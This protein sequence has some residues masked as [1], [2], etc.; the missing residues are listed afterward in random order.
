MK[1]KLAQI[2]TNGG[3]QPR[4]EI[5][6][7]KVDEYLEDMNNGAV[8]PAIAVFYDGT[9][10]WLADGYHR[11]KAHLKA[12]YHDIECDIHQGTQR[13]AILYSVGAN[14]THG[15]RRTNEDKRRAVN[16]LL[17]D[18]EWSQWSNREIAKRCRVSEGMVR[19]LR[20]KRS[21]TATYTTKHG[22]QATMNTSN[23]GTVQA[24]YDKAP[25]PVK[26]QYNDGQVTAAQ[27]YEITTILEDL[28]LSHIPT[29]GRLVAGNVDK[30]KIIARLYSTSGSP[31]TNGT[32]EALIQSKGIAY[33][34]DNH[35]FVD[36]ESAS[37]DE[38][39]KALRDIAR[40]HAIIETQAAATSE[41]IAKQSKRGNVATLNIT[42]DDSYLKVTIKNNEITCDGRGNL[43]VTVD[44]MQAL[45]DLYKVK[46]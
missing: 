45:I 40:S 36:F 21:D 29:A 13:D 5:N 4:A 30:A 34:D 35:G 2:I 3:T 18:D 23:I 19:S 44:E 38:I 28:P 22:T 15:L 25:E 32:Y 26:R 8:F 39:N 24:I 7:F 43:A 20:T 41:R 9:S 14:A 12:G 33:D 37:V 6:P 42:Q 31:T 17:N 27:A 46:E 16:R 1:L 11:L 10:Y